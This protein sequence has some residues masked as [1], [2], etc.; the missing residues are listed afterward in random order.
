MFIP[1]KDQIKEFITTEQAK[2]EY[3]SYALGHAFI[4][5]SL[6]NGERFVGGYAHGVADVQKLCQAVK[7]KFSVVTI[8][9][10]NLD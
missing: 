8:C 4:W 2:K 9:D 1:I 10:Y 5:V 6:R 7:E 3:G